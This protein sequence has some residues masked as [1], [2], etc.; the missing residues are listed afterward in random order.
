MCYEDYYE[1]LEWLRRME[2]LRRQRERADARRQEG[3]AGPSRPAA[4]QPV[5][6]EDPV[7]V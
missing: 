2:E 5:K 4:P 7:P 1:R 6:E 3:E